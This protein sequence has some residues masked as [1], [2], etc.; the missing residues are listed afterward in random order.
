MAKVQITDTILRD[1]HQ[2][3]AATRMRTDEMLP[4]CEM[5]DKVGYYS[6]ECWGGILKKETVFNE[7]Y[8]CCQ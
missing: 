4:A 7:S 3:Q 8:V 2:S 1:G 5:L 6:L